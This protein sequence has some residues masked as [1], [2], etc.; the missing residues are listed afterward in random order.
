MG[1]NIS[2]ASVNFRRTDLLG[3]DVNKIVHCIRVCVHYVKETR[4]HNAELRNE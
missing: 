3:G 2:G 4:F 1:L